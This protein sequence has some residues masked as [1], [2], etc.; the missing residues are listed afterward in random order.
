ML[1]IYQHAQFINLLIYQQ[2]KI[3]WLPMLLYIRQKN[4][5]KTLDLFVQSVFCLKSSLVCHSSARHPES[6]LLLRVL[7]HR[8]VLVSCCQHTQHLLLRGDHADCHQVSTSLS[9]A[10]ILSV[11]WLLRDDDCSHRKQF[12][13]DLRCVKYFTVQFWLDN[14]FLRPLHHYSDLWKFH[15]TVPVS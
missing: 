13:E 2:C 15:S 10:Q 12:T 8:D 5:R 9:P 4:A 11:R 7:H 3:Q 6:A 1:L 14:P